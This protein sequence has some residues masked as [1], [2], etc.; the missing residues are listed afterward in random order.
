MPCSAWNSL[1][2]AEEEESLRREKIEGENE[3]LRSRDLHV[4][5]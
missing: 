5:D 4:T 3:G 1:G 2:N